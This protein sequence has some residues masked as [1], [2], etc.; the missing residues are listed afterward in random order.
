MS[1]ITPG[2]KRRNSRAFNEIIEDNEYSI[3]VKKYI[4]SQRSDTRFNHRHSNISASGAPLLSPS[5]SILVSK[6]NNNVDTKCILESSK[7]SAGDNSVMGEVRIDSH[8]VY[9]DRV[10]NKDIA[11]DVS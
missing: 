4:T 9:I 10:T 3:Q 8:S 5:I 6:I 11:E 7:S 2:S 1:I